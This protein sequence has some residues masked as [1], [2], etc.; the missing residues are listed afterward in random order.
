MAVALLLARLLLSAVFLIAGFAKL[1]DLPGSQKALRQFGVPETLARPLGIVLPLV[2]VVTAIALVSVHWAWYGATGALILLL[3]FIAGM[4]YNLARGRRPDCHCFGQL[5]SAPVGP[6]TLVRNTLLALVAAL[7]AW[8]GHGN[9][10]LSATNWFTTWSLAQQITLITA[11]IAIVLIAG[12]GWFLLQ[13]LSQQGRLLLRTERL[14]SRLAQAGIVFGIPGQELSN[15]G[16]PVGTKAPAFSGSGL[17]HETISLT[18]LRALGKPIVLI[19]TN[20][21]CAP[22][23]TLMPEVERWQYDYADKLTIAL[24]SRG[25]VEDNRAKTSEHHLCRLVL[26][27]QDEIDKLYDIHGTPSAVLIHSDG[28][29]DSPL[30]VGPE[31]IRALVERAANLHQAPLMPL[32]PSGNHQQKTA[33]EPIF[34]GIGTPALDFS[35]PD[36]NGKPVF[37]SSCLGTPTLLLFWNPDCGFC[38][39]MLPDLQAWEANPPQGAPRLLIIS[40]GTARENRAMG[41]HSP[42]LLDAE[43]EVS[44]RFGADGTPMAIVVDAQG[45]VA[46]TLVGG[47]P[48]TLAL[49]GSVKVAPQSLLA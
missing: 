43:G 6:S 15:S 37:L 24:I 28:L 11:I 49:A 18:A 48:D 4:S 31:T 36:L 33:P 16:L 39:K 9:T 22:C 47:A 46:S 21:H 38:K 30:A 12:E 14:E 2:E 19:F 5:H 27:N 10:N 7:V 29:I 3:A 23:S 34:P 35:L 41:L 45:R 8:L 26:Q 44:K 17:D 25:S 1:A 42:V 20:P 32:I 13:T 40:N